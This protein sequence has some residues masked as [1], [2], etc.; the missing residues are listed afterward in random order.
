MDQNN[1]LISHF[2]KFIFISVNSWFR[3]NTII[4]KNKNNINFLGKLDN[5]LFYVNIFILLVRCALEH[6][7]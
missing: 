4:I 1:I 2:F 3:L 7:I 5:F 6:V